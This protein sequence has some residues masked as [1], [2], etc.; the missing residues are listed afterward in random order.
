PLRSAPL[1]FAQ[2]RFA[3]QR[4]APRRFASGRSAPPLGFAPA[5]FV[6][7]RVAPPG[8]R[9]ARRRSRGMGFF[10]RHAFQAATPFL[11]IATCSSFAMRAP[12]L[13]LGQLCLDGAPS[14]LQGPYLLFR[15]GNDLI[16]EGCEQQLKS[17][18]SIDRKHPVVLPIVL[19][20]RVGP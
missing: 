10:S 1:R 4:L 6:S 15:R 17:L 7:L 16:G 11:S 18:V 3:P 20:H 2:L 5:R 14:I 13:K 12:L 9:S 8:L 19:E